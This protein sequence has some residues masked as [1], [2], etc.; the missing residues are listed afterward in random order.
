[1]AVCRSKG[2]LNE[3]KE[4]LTR[5]DR[6]NA[7]P[8]R[9]DRCSGRDGRTGLQTVG[10]QRGHLLQLAEAVR[11]DETRAG[12]GAAGFLQKENARLRKLMADQATYA[13]A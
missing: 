12:Q 7:S 3:T 9:R 11:P 5:T 8:G 6:S 1:M 13:S 4:P 2:T 10:H